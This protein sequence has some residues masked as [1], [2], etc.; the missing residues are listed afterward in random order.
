MEWERTHNSTATGCG[1]A[2][3]L[4]VR[5]EAVNEE[6]EGD[7]L[8]HEVERAKLKRHGLLRVE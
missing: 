3:F 8:Q 6:G 2:M 5:H 1:D 4:S 7:L